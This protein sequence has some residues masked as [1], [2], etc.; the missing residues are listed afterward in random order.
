M[1]GDKSEAA[2]RRPDQGIGIHDLPYRTSANTGKFWN[3]PVVTPEVRRGRLQPVEEILRPP[4]SDDI[5]RVG[6]R[7]YLREVTGLEGVAIAID[8]RT[9]KPSNYKV[10][11]VAADVGDVLG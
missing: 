4:I 2:F 6:A 9:R 7:M 3:L 1:K 10:I 8:G 5:T 11:T